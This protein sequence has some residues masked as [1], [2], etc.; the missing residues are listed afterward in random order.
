MD[1]V[2]MTT[3]PVAAKDDLPGAGAARA[4]A[5]GGETLPVDPIIASVAKATTG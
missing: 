1:A 3:Q 5:T 4:D 2:T